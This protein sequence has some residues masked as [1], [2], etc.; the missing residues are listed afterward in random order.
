ML[1][2]QR[3]KPHFAQLPKFSRNFKCNTPTGTE[4]P[5]K[6]YTI[7]TTGG[8]ELIIR[9]LGKPVRLL[10]DTSAGL[11]IIK[12]RH[13]NGYKVTRNKRILSGI[14]KEMITTTEDCE[15]DCGTKT[16]TFAIVEDDLGLHRTFVETGR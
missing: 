8:A 14:T 12:R 7:N 15:I 10:A 4:P 1:P 6:I 16:H 9:V 2:M 5:S 13:T 11:N 3:F